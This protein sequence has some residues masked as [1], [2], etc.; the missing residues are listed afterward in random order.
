MKHLQVVRAVLCLLLLSG[1]A[2]GETDRILLPATVG[3]IPGPTP[4]RRDGILRNEAARVI[5]QLILTYG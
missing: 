4:G 1:F 3:E 2:A 5:D